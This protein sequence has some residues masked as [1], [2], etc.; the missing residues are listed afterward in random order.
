MD[1]VPP[2]PDGEEEMP[3]QDA[4]PRRTPFGDEHTWGHA[5][6]F[7]YAE[8][9]EEKDRFYLTPLMVLKGGG[10]GR[11]EVEVDGNLVKA[12]FVIRPP[13]LCQYLA[14][15][16]ENE[17]KHIRDPQNLYTGARPVPP[18]KVVQLPLNYIRVAMCDLGKRTP[19]PAL[20]QQENGT[21]HVS[22]EEQFSWECR[23]ND[24]ATIL[25]SLIEDGKVKFQVEYAFRG[26]ALTSSELRVTTTQIMSRAWDSKV[27]PGKDVYSDKQYFSLGQISSTVTESLESIRIEWITDSTF[28]PSVSEIGPEIV[29][30]FLAKATQPT[31]I[32]WA[33]LDQ[34]EGIYVGPESFKPDIVNKIAQE[35]Q[36]AVSHLVDQ[37]VDEAYQSAKSGQDIRSYESL[38]EE[39][40]RHIAG[41]SGSGSFLGIGA[42]ASGSS[43]YLKQFKDQVNTKS[44]SEW[45]SDLKTGLT[46]RLI[47]QLNESSSMKFSWDGTKV[48]PKEIEIRRVTKDGVENDQQLFA[49]KAIRAPEVVIKGCWRYSKFTDKSPPAGDTYLAFEEKIENLRS[50][51]Q[52]GDNA[53]ASKIA[54]LDPR[55]SA[56]ESRIAS[57]TGSGALDALL[58]ALHVDGDH[59]HLEGKYLHTHDVIL[60]G[61]CYITGFPHGNL[62]W[63]ITR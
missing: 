24:Q 49:R 1:G 43:D 61:D 57:L 21:I 4:R 20:M 27:A 45:K 5:E 36:N 22:D 13:G 60:T 9:A 38:S 28:P 31:I 51:M 59:L 48:V 2:E 17:L 52:S 29:Q 32:G 14:D 30:A 10:D 62:R 8:E 16:L 25:K 12:W 3:N 54:S 15:Y 44:E 41:A 23:D 39:L 33:Q 56:L 11:P 18:Q 7:V 42:S 37:Y 47:D 50:A 6:V 26:E 40:R 55:I 63:A 35:T 58:A 46:K 53:L 34:Y 19:L